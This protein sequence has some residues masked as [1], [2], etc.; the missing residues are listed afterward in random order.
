MNTIKSDLEI[1]SKLIEWKSSLKTM[2]LDVEARQWAKVRLFCVESKKS[3]AKHFDR[4]TNHLLPFALGND[5]TETSKLIAKHVVLLAEQ[6]Q[7]EQPSASQTNNTINTHQ[8]NESLT[9]VHEPL[10]RYVSIE[11]HD[12]DVHLG[13]FQQFLNDH[14]KK[15]PDKMNPLFIEIAKALVT[16]ETHLWDKTAGPEIVKLSENFSSQCM[17]LASNTQGTEQGVKEAALV[18]VTGKGEEMRSVLAIIRSGLQPA[19]E[20]L[21]GKK[22]ALAALKHIV[23]QHKWLETKEPVQL[24]VD[25]DT[26]SKLL[27]GDHFK[28]KRLG[29][30]KGKIMSQN[31]KHKKKN[32][33]QQNKGINTTTQI[34][35]LVKYSMARKLK[36]NNLVIAELHHRGLSHLDTTKDGGEVEANITTKVARL[37][38]H[39]KERCK[40]QKGS[41]NKAKDA[42]HPLSCSVGMFYDLMEP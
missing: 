32:K 1:S 26:I 27:K 18:S 39:E 42:F 13:R 10:D 41:D 30:K 21:A 38:E 9:I 35:G 20:G 2:P 29:E 25:R 6:Q 24:Q 3:L 31:P 28:N 12:R 17:A 36:M 34:A 15:L 22:K 23:E 5:E 40:G 7:L 16:A 33:A 8:P 14:A 19:C 4:W 37:A 11:S